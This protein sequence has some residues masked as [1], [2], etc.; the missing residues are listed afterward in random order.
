MSSNLY[1]KDSYTTANIPFLFNSTII[2]YDMKDAGYSLIREFKQL[3]EHT[4]ERLGKLPKDMRKKQIGVLERDDK[5]FKEVHK[6]SFVDARELFFISNNIEDG[7][8]ISIKKDAI[9][10]TKEC[11]ETKLSNYIE[12][13]PKHKYTSFLNLMLKK[14]IEVYYNP[15]ETD[16]KGISD[17]KL[18][19]HQNYMLK[20]ISSFIKRM[21][22]DREVD[23]IEYT[24]RFIDKYKGRKLEKEYYR[25]FNADSLFRLKGGETTL[26]VEDYDVW[27]LDIHWNFKWILLDLIRIPL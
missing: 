7:D 3:P 19:W 2:E 18:L 13:R 22:N 16:V 5:D 14:R 9:F 20:F 27:D 15:E 6:Q 23:V 11:D 25:E 24:K 10:V 21:E 17:D 26:D 12:F 4:I 1:K 8:I